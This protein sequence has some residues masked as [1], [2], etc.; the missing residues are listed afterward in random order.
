MK[1][2][3]KKE[4]EEFLRWKAEQKR[5]AELEQSQAKEIIKPKN[6]ENFNRK[7]PHSNENLENDSHGSGFEVNF[8]LLVIGTVI[9][10]MFL[11]LLVFISVTNNTRKIAERSK[12][13]KIQ[14]SIKA[15]KK[16]TIALQQAKAKAIQDSIQRVERIRTLK[17]SVKITTLKLC[18]PN[19][20]S[21]CDAIIYYKNISNKTIKYFDWTGH[22]INAVGD[23]VPCEIRGYSS[24]TGRDTGPVRPGK[25]SGG[26]WSCIIY[27]WS[28]RKLVLTGVTVQYTDG[29]EL[30]ISQNELKYIR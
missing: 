20:A 19:S 18:S 15:V 29:S 7:R 6:E 21:G 1:E 11:F 2:E 5:K 22:C 12:Q 27:N 3:E 17:N 13:E 30:D 26:I 8:K 14:D 9:I 24:Y 25:S 28:A 23:I 10:F 4:F 16:K